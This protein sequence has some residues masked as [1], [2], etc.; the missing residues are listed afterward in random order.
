MFYSHAIIPYLFNKYNNNED[1]FK[2]L[3]PKEPEARAKVDQMLHY[4][5]GV[6]YVAFWQLT[7]SNI[8][9]TFLI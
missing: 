3:Y 9:F 4:D 7:V 8:I 5:N 1:R 2:K 6:F